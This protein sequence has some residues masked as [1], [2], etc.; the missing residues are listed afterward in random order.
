M[1]ISNELTV[2][3]W[4]KEILAVSLIFYQIIFKYKKYLLRLESELSAKWN[5]CPFFF[6]LQSHTDHILKHLYAI[7]IRVIRGKLK[8][9]KFAKLKKCLLRMWRLAEQKRDECLWKGTFRWITKCVRI[10]L[11]LHIKVITEQWALKVELEPSSQE[12]V[13]IKCISKLYKILISK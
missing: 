4:I 7:G 8:F 9:I 12:L 5:Q 10:C 1:T 2:F 6:K 3:K 13:C 11:L